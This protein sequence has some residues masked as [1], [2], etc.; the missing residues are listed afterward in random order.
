VQPWLRRTRAPMAPQDR[1]LVGVR[2]RLAPT[3]SSSKRASKGFKHSFQFITNTRELARWSIALGPRPRKCSA[4]ASGVLRFHML[5]ANCVI[6]TSL[7]ILQHCRELTH[8]R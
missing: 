4:T 7:P 5:S 2:P 8:Y 6:T 3:E 1:Q